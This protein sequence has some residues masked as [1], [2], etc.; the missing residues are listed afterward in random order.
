MGSAPAL[1]GRQLRG[2]ASSS[3]TLRPA[4]CARAVTRSLAGGLSLAVV[5]ASSAE[6]TLDPSLYSEPS[7][8]AYWGDGPDASPPFRELRYRAAELSRELFDR[9]IQ[10]GRVFVVEDLG[11]NGPM[12]TWDCDYFRSDP[13]FST[14][15]MVQ[16]YAASSGSGST[17]RVGLRSEWVSEEAKTGAADSEA[18]QKAPFYWGIKDVQFGGHSKTWK[19]EMLKK[20]HKNIQL[21]PFMDPDNAEWFKRTPEFWFA[22]PGAGAMAHMD[23]HVQPTLSLQLA[24]TKRWRLSMMEP[25]LG[26]YL[27]MIYA[28]GAVYSRAEPWQPHFNVT[29][30]PGEALFFPPGFIH[31]TLNLEDSPGSCSASVTFQFERPMAARL[32]RTFLP[33]IRRTADIHEAWPILARWA[34]LLGDAPKKGLSYEAA[35]AQALGSGAAG[36]AFEAMDS[37]SNGSLSWQEL[38]RAAGHADA[39]DLLAF[40]DLDEDGTV[41]RHEFAEVFGFWASMERAAIQE[42]PKR[43]RNLQLRHLDDDFN[44]EDLPDKVTAELLREA[45][46]QEAKVRERSSAKAGAAASR[47]TTSEL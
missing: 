17:K 22:G 1:H 33:R 9:H 37:D 29:T 5:S 24:G 15:E 6:L 36:A 35:K 47:A 19:Q 46:A 10:D 42:T 2:S 21:P 12:A 31:E 8:S 38:K 23:S 45:Q 34:A 44:I 11:K 13:V 20:V 4:R 25:R 28:D 32:Y 18:P 40:H 7:A 30:R 3:A 14:A 26:P 41:S 27:A 39:K 43:F 16:Q